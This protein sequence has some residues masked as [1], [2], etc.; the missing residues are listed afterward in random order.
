MGLIAPG[1]YL[2][3]PT[4]EAP[5]F[6]LYSVSNMPTIT[7]RWELGVQWEPFTGDRAALRPSEC[8][9]DYST[10]VEVRRGEAY[11]DG[12]PFVVVG[13][14]ACK[15]QSRPISEAEERAVAHLN[16][17]EERAV[18][19]AI[20]TGVMGNLPS[21]Q[22]ATDVTS[23]PGTAV[24]TVQGIALLES[25]L[26]QTHGGIGALHM[27]RAFGAFEDSDG[28]VRRQGEHIETLLGNY[29]AFGGGYDL[30]NVGP[31]GQPAPAGEA[32]LYATGRP[33]VLRGQVFTQPDDAHYLNK[34]D[35]DVVI[36]A[37]REVLVMWD[38]PTLAVLVNRA[39]ATI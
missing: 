7:D 33:T 23:T 12:I 39:V 25:A 31:D 11:E 16:A 30:A 3:A 19:Y 29:V 35:N 2:A 34:D 6:G 28:V 5:R 18:E 15:A 17:G 27:P 21:F 20:A 10:D 1:K 38:G 26:A 4:L 14:Y 36:L 37:Q 8:V 13:S 32:W 24:T 9:D 22:G